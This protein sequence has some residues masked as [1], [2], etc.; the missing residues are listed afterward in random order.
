MY[1]LSE[2]AE[3]FNMERTE[4]IEA[5]ID[6]RTLLDNH[7]EK[8]MGITYV[9][10][11]GIEILYKLLIAPSKNNNQGNK[12]L[13]ENKMKQ[14]N[15]EAFK[16]YINIE[17]KLR[18]NIS[19]LKNDILALDTEIQKKDKFLIDYQEKLLEINRLLV[20]YEENLLLDNL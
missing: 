17:E 15:T 5:L 13:K 18:L 8:K 20:K 7:V 2:I 3:N 19:E 9:D 4:I 16:D 11:R 6:H 10:D 1:K 12:P 14:Y